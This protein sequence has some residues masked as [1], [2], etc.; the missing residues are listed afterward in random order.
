P[1]SCRR[2]WSGSSWDLPLIDGMVGVRD[3]PPRMGRVQD[4]VGPVRLL[5][6]TTDRKSAKAPDAAH[7]LGAA[8]CEV[9]S[10]SDEVPVGE[11]GLKRR[12][13]LRSSCSEMKAR[14]Q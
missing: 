4:E 3:D 14:D 10:D 2:P 5:D 11:S 7:R 6:Q 12:P 13:E 8:R 9:A 1:D